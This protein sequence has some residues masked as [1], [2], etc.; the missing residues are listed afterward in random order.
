MSALRRGLLGTA[1]NIRV[2]ELPG[3]PSGHSI[4]VQLRAAVRFSVW[5]DEPR[6]PTYPSVGPIML[7]LTPDRA[8]ELQDRLTMAA[9]RR[10]VRLFMDGRLLPTHPDV[11][12]VFTYREAS[13]GPVVFP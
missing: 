13:T 11:L 12:T 1:A 4:T 6:Q 9:T 2:P 10:G 3:K 7:P 5:V 8:R